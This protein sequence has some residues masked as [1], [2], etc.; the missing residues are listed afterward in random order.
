MLCY[1]APPVTTPSSLF[2]YCSVNFCEFVQKWRNSVVDPGHGS[3]PGIQWGSE[4]TQFTG[5][6]C[7]PLTS[8]AKINNIH[9]VG[10]L[11][12]KSKFCQRMMHNTMSHAEFYFSVFCLLKMAI[13]WVCLRHQMVIKYWE[14]TSVSIKYSP[15]WKNGIFQLSD[16]K[17]KNWLLFSL[18]KQKLVTFYLL[19]DDDASLRKVNGESEYLRL[20]KTLQTRDGTGTSNRPVRSEFQ[21]SRSV[22]LHAGRRSTRRSPVYMPVADLLTGHQLC[23]IC[24]PAFIICIHSNFYWSRLHLRDWTDTGNQPVADL[25]AGHRSACRLPVCMPVTGLH[26]GCQS[27]CRSPVCMPVTGLHA[28]HRSACRSPVCM[29]V[30]GLHAGHRSACRSPIGPANR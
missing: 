14:T 30:T 12:L 9:G 25:H 20:K 28:D 2:I 24:F 13:A 1:E 21:T 10:K 16:R 6:C 26:A 18:Q 7:F 5:I 3:N 22:S 17:I 8:L 4:N 27:A 23:F 19:F 29:P 15:L 11:L